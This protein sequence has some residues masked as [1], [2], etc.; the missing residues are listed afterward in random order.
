LTAAGAQRPARPVFDAVFSGEA[1]AG[2]ALLRE[3]L[4]AHGRR[5]REQETPEESSR[6]AR[7]E[8]VL[9]SAPA[10]SE[11]ESLPCV[12]ALQRETPGEAWLSVSLSRGCPLGCGFCSVRLC[13]GTRQR[14]VFLEKI[15]AA[16]QRLPARLS[17][18]RVHLNFEDDNLLLDE[19]WFGEVLAFFRGHFPGAGFAAE[20]G[21][22][23]RLLSPQTLARL[24]DA[25]FEKFNLS[26]AGMDEEADGTRKTDMQAYLAAAAAI[27]RRGTPLVSYFIAGLPADNPQTIVRRLVFMARSPTLAG[28]SLFYPV[29]GIAGFDPP[30]ELLRRHPGLAR[31]STAYPG[32]VL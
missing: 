11:A 6:G 25:G 12:F 26:L 1:E 8:S 17:E 7:Q 28:I 14:R 15:R 24:I 18:K 27:A 20:N 16:A 22:D 9:I 19:K 21:L 29:P 32:R 30:P 5:Q 2:F 23:Y 10:F 13:H 31:G 3:F 4:E